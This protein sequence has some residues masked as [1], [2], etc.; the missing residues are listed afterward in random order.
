[1]LVLDL[2]FDVEC[3]LFIILVGCNRELDNLGPNTLSRAGLDVAIVL[4]LALASLLGRGSGISGGDGY[5]STKS[6][7]ISL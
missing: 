3:L 5:A 6:V 7:E 2:G 1:M 4:A